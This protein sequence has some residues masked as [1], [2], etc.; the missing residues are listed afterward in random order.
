MIYKLYTEGLP[1]NQ[2]IGHALIA[3]NGKEW[4]YAHICAGK[5][6]AS[7]YVEDAIAKWAKME[8][9]HF[10]NQRKLAFTN[11]GVFN[12]TAQEHYSNIKRITRTLNTVI[13]WRSIVEFHESINYFKPHKDSIHAG[14]LP[15]IAQI[16]HYAQNS[17]HSYLLH[18]A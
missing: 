3:I 7:N 12:A 17:T 9:D 1:G 14:W 13:T 6:Q 8:L 15:V 4:S 18:T 2:V 11:K 16:I 10:A 5:T